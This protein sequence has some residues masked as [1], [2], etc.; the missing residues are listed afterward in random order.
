MSEP[1]PFHSEPEAVRKKYDYRRMLMNQSVKLPARLAMKL[2]GPDCAF[3]LYRSHEG[4]TGRGST[5]SKKQK[6]RGGS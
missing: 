2:M 1:D 4:D 6:K 3:H 5:K